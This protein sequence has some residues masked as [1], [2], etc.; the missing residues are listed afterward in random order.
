MLWS[1][2]N[3]RASSDVSFK[4]HS[5]VLALA[6]RY[7]LSG[8]LNHAAPEIQGHLGVPGPGKERDFFTEINAR[9]AAS[10]HQ[11]QLT[12]IE[13]N[14]VLVMAVCEYSA[15]VRINQNG[16]YHVLAYRSV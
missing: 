4:N 7:G 12:T 13:D 3:L 11:G 5:T 16:S 2:S 10:K 9:L 8:L 6:A 15:R 14:P 1:T